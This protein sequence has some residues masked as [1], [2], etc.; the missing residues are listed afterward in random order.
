M[1][2]LASWNIVGHATPRAE[3]PDKVTGMGKYGMD[4]LLPGM[5]WCK[6]L[7]SPF[8]HA[9]IVSIDT[10]EAAGLPGVHL[11]LTG[12]DLEGVR[13]NRS[14]YK[15]EPALCWDTVLYVGDKVAAVV[16][17]DED[18]AQRALDLIQVEYE[19][20]TPVLTAREAAQP[21][22]PILHPDFA[23]YA[24]VREAPETPTNVLVALNRG[25]GDVEAG[26][27]AAD[28]IVEETYT[29]PH[30]HQAY[31]EPHAVLVDV[32]E[33]GTAQI[34]MSCQLPA[35]NIGELI[36]VLEL[37]QE[38]VIINSSYIGGSFGGK[39][40]ATGV[41]IMYQFAR[42][43]GRPIKLV[44]DYSEE[45]MASNP[46]HPSEIRVKAGVRRDGTITAWQADAYLA[47]GAY[48]SYAP[49]PNGLRGVFEMGGAYRCE[50]V[51][52]TITHT[53]ANLVPCGFA[54]APGMPQGLWAGESHI[55]L[56]ARAIGMDPAE[57]RARNITRDGEPL[58][59][60][61]TYQALRA[62]ATLE[63]ALRAANYSAPRP[64]NGGR[65]IGTGH[66]SQ[67]GGAAAAQVTIDANGGI[68]A[69]FST[70]DTGGGTYTI[71]AQVVAE[72]LGVSPQEVQAL[73]FPS[74][75]IGPLQGIGGSRGARVT[76]TVGHMA[77]AETAAKLKRLAAEFQGW[78]EERL[79]L[80]GGDVVNDGTGE[81]I[82]FG[83]I[84]ARTGEPLVTRVDIQEGASPYTAYGTQIAEVEV[85]PE[86]GE[87]RVLRITAVHET[88]RV[89]NP[90]AFY[91]QLEGGVVYGFG[92]TVMTETVYDESG[93][94]TNPSFADMKLPT[95]R[96]L[97]ELNEIVLESD[98]GDGPYAVR[99]IGEHTNIMTAPA[100]ANAIEDAVGVRITS[101]PITA[102]KVYLALQEKRNG[103]GIR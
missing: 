54:R 1:T 32:E 60:G 10:A 22:A 24:G 36:R 5:L 41:Y 103:D 45:L 99:G 94:V 51:A 74:N 57:F 37:P 68:T 81:S 9:R 87:V 21:D 14:A 85:D 77:A 59:N 79:S 34:W 44:F 55:D 13:T 98:V 31:L 18:I 52:M 43:T 39:T 25:R 71:I 4:R 35:A 90:V 16:A 97:P 102:E 82:P 95:M 19:E 50:N 75:R 48:S 6:I 72:Q 29:T 73:S 3:G 42:R 84:A 15:D 8:A 26:F 40:D 62:E 63:E 91:G 12:K 38:K 49:I 67:G 2:E 66:H 7:R 100:I 65:G 64:A 28:V 80:R 61:D 23:G 86:T 69:H 89:L 30:Q 88:G 92:E 46:R 96:D 101:L 20:L 27:A 58:M 53:Y 76:S 47:V 93:R 17:D 33:D 11:I 70:F 56:C 78:D 83:Q